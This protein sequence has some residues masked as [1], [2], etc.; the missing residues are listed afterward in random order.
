MESNLSEPAHEPARIDAPAGRLI[1]VDPDALLF[2]AEAA[3]LTGL[4]IRTL[5]SY[6]VR[7]GGPEYF[8]L[9]RRAV[10]YRRREVMAWLELRRRRSTSD[11]GPDAGDEQ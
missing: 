7:G 5:Q 2:E 9:G 3:Y 4:S 8:V 6:R 1:P 11:P 10:R